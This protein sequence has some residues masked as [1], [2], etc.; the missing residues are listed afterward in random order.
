MIYIIADASSVFGQ[1][2]L[3]LDHKR[4]TSGQSTKWTLW[5]WHSLW[6]PG[7]M[8][9][10]MC[11]WLSALCNSIGLLS[12]LLYGVCFF[13]LWCYDKDISSNGLKESVFVLKISGVQ[14]STLSSYLLAS[15]SYDTRNHTIW[16]HFHYRHILTDA[17]YIHSD[18]VAHLRD[19]SVKCDHLICCAGLIWERFRKLFLVSSRWKLSWWLSIMGN[20]HC[21]VIDD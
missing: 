14:V 19:L 7:L 2:L 6:H 8:G 3:Y 16:A 21:L 13:L 11:R 1:Y 15:S 20:S 17:V 18:N 12:V 5:N 10:V 9:T 4:A